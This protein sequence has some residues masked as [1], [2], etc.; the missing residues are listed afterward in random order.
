MDY[1]V[2]IA[3]QLKA[4]DIRMMRMLGEVVMALS[5]STREDATEEAKSL[6]LP[7][8]MD[9]GV[10]FETFGV[11]SAINGKAIDLELLMDTPDEVL[12]EAAKALYGLGEK[13]RGKLGAISVT[14][15]PEGQDV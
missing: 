5:R 10:C 14:L 15:L 7:A 8:I 12:L 4:G 1:E 2:K 9:L 11:G 3:S 13:E 6:V